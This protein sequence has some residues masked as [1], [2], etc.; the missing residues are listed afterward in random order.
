MLRFV[1]PA[2]RDTVYVEGLLGELFLDR[3]SDVER[4]LATFRY[5][6]ENVAQ[7]EQLS[8]KTLDA[9]RREWAGR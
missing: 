3:E 9:V 4:Y 2:I 8:R 6:S 5:I 1:I 7:D